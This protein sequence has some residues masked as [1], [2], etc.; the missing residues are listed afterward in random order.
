MSHQEHDERS[1]DSFEADTA[2]E[3]RLDAGQPQLFT[4]RVSIFIELRFAIALLSVIVLLTMSVVNMVLERLLETELYTLGPNL[5]SPLRLLYY[6][7]PSLTMA[8]VLTLLLVWINRFL[9]HRA[10]QT[11]LSN[12]FGEKLVVSRPPSIGQSLGVAFISIGLLVSLWFT[13][14]IYLRF[15]PYLS[16]TLSEVTLS[17]LAAIPIFTSAWLAGTAFWINIIFHRRYL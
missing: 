1:L 4:Q 13:V 7:L 3:Y 8:I 11:A 12:P 5:P 10:K 6:T 16:D 15:G 14:S 9:G 2:H 17:R